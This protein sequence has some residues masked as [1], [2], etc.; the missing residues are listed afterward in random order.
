MKL[1]ENVSCNGRVF[2]YKVMEGLR[3]DATVIDQFDILFK[4][5]CEYF[6][7]L[8]AQLY[9]MSLLDEFLHNRVHVVVI[10]HLVVPAYIHSPKSSKKIQ[11][12]K[13]K[14]YKKVDKI[15]IKRLINIYR[16]GLIQ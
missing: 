6:S 15:F 5:V 4:G 13:S 2:F 3:A 12:I 7:F 16:L 1:N 11:N 9:L 8:M 14:F 10:A